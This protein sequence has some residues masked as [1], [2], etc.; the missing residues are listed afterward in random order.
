LLA[1]ID[2]R[3]LHLEPKTK[4]LYQFPERL[5]PCVTLAA[6]PD[7]TCYFLMASISKSPSHAQANTFF[8]DFNLT[9]DDSVE[10]YRQVERL[11]LHGIP[12]ERRPMDLRRPQIRLLV[13][14][15]APKSFFLQKKDRQGGPETQTACPEISCIEE[16]QRFV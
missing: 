15:H 4:R 14:D 16:F 10:T 5:R 11:S 7:Q 1:F 3:F 9:G 13:I 12:A 8:P 2:F 6:I